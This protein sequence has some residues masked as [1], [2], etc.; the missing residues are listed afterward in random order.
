VLACMC[1][2]LY[3]EFINSFM[4][5]Y[6]L[7]WRGSEWGTVKIAFFINRYSAVIGMTMYLVY[8]FIDMPHSICDKIHWIPLFITVICFISSEFILFLRIYAIWRK[9]L[10]VAVP[11]L[12]LLAIIISLTIWT[13]AFNFAM[14]LP[15]G[16]MGCISANG[17]KVAKYAWVPLLFCC[18]YDGMALALTLAEILRA[19]REGSEQSPMLV[20]LLRDG[21]N[22]FAVVFSVKLAAILNYRHNKINPSLLVP[23]AAVIASIM[24]SRLL[25]RVKE[26]RNNSQ[27]GKLS[28][29][30]SWQSH[31]HG[32]SSENRSRT[33][34]S[35][36][37]GSHKNDSL[38]EKGAQA[39][40]HIREDRYYDVELN[41]M[42]DNVRVKCIAVDVEI[43]ESEDH[44]SAA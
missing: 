31:S 16:E 34:V 41:R 19:R 21:V 32:A 6:R 9:R 1:A 7:I 15:D 29:G 4:N 3:W 23:V 18:F 37:K 42:P 10:W 28:F 26:A 13:N 8:M 14:E 36:T 38:S 39:Q 30:Y 5:E 2:I 35:S 20:L 25:F 27:N 33:M 44:V 22:Y 12:S 40:E 17:D 43:A 24:C 11:F